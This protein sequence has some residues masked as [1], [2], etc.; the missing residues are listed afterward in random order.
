[1]SSA[2]LPR[3][4]FSDRALRQME[5]A[6]TCRARRAGAC[7]PRPHTPPCSARTRR[8][9][10]CRPCSRSA[11]TAECRAPLCE[12]SGV[13]RRP[14]R[15]RQRKTPQIVSVCKNELPPSASRLGRART[16]IRLCTQL[17]ETAECLS[18][19]FRLGR[20][21]TGVRLRTRFN[22]TLRQ[23]AFAAVAGR[24]CLSRS[25][26]GS[27]AA[28]RDEK[29]LFGEYEGTFRKFSVKIPAEDFA[30]PKISITF[31]LASKDWRDSSAG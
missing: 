9:C 16:G 21:R 25:G 29:R 20:A 12:K 2:A 11:H 27:F 19:V 18:S 26:T 1:M 6:G 17:Y 4:G 30:C 3:G 14:R 22:E 15:L 23:S 8:R 28:V 31:A 10:A 7:A 5:A 13:C 24:S